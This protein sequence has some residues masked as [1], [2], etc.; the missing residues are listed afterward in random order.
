[1]K[2]KTVRARVIKSGQSIGTSVVSKQ[3][4]SDYE[5]DSV[6]TEIIMPKYPP[7]ILKVIVENSTILQQCITAYKQNICGFGLSTVYRDDDSV[8]DETDEMKKE[9]ETMRLLLRQFNF[10]KPHKD[11]WGQ[12][13]ADREETGNG[14]IEVIRDGLNKPVGLENVNPETMKVTKKGEAVSININGTTIPIKKRFR[15][16]IQETKGKKVWF[17]EFG[18]PRIMDSRTGEYDVNTPEEHQAHEIIHLKIGSGP[19]GIPRWIGHLPHITGARKAEELNLKYFEQGR[20]TPLAILIKNGLLSDESEAALK[21]Y[22]ES[23]EGVDNAHKFLL[24]E[25]EGDES[26]SSMPGESNPKVD[27]EIKSLADMLQQDA[28]FQE[29]DDNSRQ[30]VQSAF[31]LPDIYIGRSRDFNRATADMARQITE[32]QVFQPERD[33]LSFIINHKLLAEYDFRYVEVVFNGPEIS[34]A[35]DATRLI[36]VGNVA[37]AITPN[38][39]RAYI[40]KRVFNRDLDNLAIPE[41]DIPIALQKQQQNSQPVELQKA[42]NQDVVRILKDLCDV[43]EDFQGRE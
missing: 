38:D 25:V 8:G 2:Q 3:E 33:S 34:D 6:Y 43:L 16:Y 15:K 24:L 10:D 42:A 1:M 23:V 11:I 18:D 4:L 21:E 19:Y 29:Y 31:R 40:G 30:K 14:Y 35:Q 12:G 5:A 9:W 27:I 36:G 20:H 22:A 13:I 28:L 37:G 26:E 39:L 32:E 17:K 7:R 41:A